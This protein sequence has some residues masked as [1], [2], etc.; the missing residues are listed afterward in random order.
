MLAS[1]IYLIN[2]LKKY[3]WLISKKQKTTNR[4]GSK[5]IVPKW[6]S[7][8]SG[9]YKGGQRIN[10]SKRI[11]FSECLSKEISVSLL[12]QSEVLGPCHVLLR[13]TIVRPSTRN[14]SILK[15]RIRLGFINLTKIRFTSSI[16]AVL[17]IGPQKQCIE[18]SWFTNHF[19]QIVESK[20]EKY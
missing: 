15:R 10:V 7:E 12:W 16:H 9:F 20:I 8:Q 11:E 18:I 4:N 13:G 2:L 3:K 1:N 5:K 17:S 19:K 14:I 6:I